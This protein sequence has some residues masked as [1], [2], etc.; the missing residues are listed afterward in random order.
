MPGGGRRLSPLPNNPHLSPRHARQEEGSVFS[1]GF[2]RS[3]GQGQAQGFENAQDVFQQQQRFQDAFSQREQAQQQLLAGRVVYQGRDGPPNVQVQQQRSNQQR[4]PYTGPGAPWAH[5]ASTSGS[6]ATEKIDNSFSLWTPSAQSQGQAQSGPVFQKQLHGLGASSEPFLQA[7][8]VD[9]QVQNQNSGEGGGSRKLQQAASA[10]DGVSEY[11]KIALQYREQKASD[12]LSES[13]AEYESAWWNSITTTLQQQ[14]ASVQEI[15]NEITVR[16]EQNLSIEQKI[17]LQHQQQMAETLRVKQEAEA[18]YKDMQ[19]A[20]LKMQ[21]QPIVSKHSAD[22]S[23]PHS[24]EYT[25]SSSGHAG[26]DSAI[27]I[28]TTNGGIKQL[29]NIC[30]TPVDLPGV[31]VSA[32]M[33]TGSQSSPSGGRKANG[34]EYFKTL[35]ARRTQ[36]TVALERQLEDEAIKF[37]VDEDWAVTLA[38]AKEEARKTVERRNSHLHLND[39]TLQPK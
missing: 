5:G 20:E 34:L 30:S 11:E 38:A 17:Q 39:Q 22:C 33:E 16:A 21:K 3:Q 14:D 27:R 15:V 18:A 19:D 35:N 2:S 6:D 36:N 25:A 31:K 10:L 26:T 23:A 9:R 4:V 28:A 13:A 1:R 32:S 7:G 29:P 24:F 8:L 37:E 12:P